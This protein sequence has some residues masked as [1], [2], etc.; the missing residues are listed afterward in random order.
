MLQLEIFISGAAVIFA[1]S[2]FFI[3]ITRKNTNLLH[4]LFA[5]VALFSAALFSLLLLQLL[6]F[7][8]IPLT[9]IGRVYIGII[10]LLGQM[11]FHSS[12][13]YPDARIKSRV[14]Q[15]ILAAIPGLG[16]VAATVGTNLV[17]SEVTFQEHLT[18]G[19]GKFYLVYV[20]LFTA[21]LFGGLIIT[22]VKLQKLQESVFRQEIIYFVAGTS[23]FLFAILLL[24]FYIPYFTGFYQLQNI[25]VAISGILILL[26]VNYSILY[27]KVLDFKMFYIKLLSWIVFFALLFTP[28]M[29]M[30]KYNTL[31]IMSRQIP[32]IGIAFLIF[33][34]LV[35]FYNF[36]KPRMESV[37]RSEYRDLAGNFTDFFQSI[38]EQAGSD[39]DVSFWDNLHTR[40]ISGFYDKFSIESASFYLFSPKRDTFVYNYSF[41]TDSVPATIES[42]DTLITCL[43]LYPNVI[44]KATLYSDKIFHKHI[45]S[46]INFFDENNIEIAMPFLNQE[47]QVIGILLLGNF[48]NKKYS[49]TFLSTLE[50]YRVRFQH[51]LSNQIR[52][53][54]VKATQ[55]VEHDKIVVKSIKNKVIPKKLKQIEGIRISSF[56]INN[57]THGGDYFDSSQLSKDKLCLFIS[58]SSYSGV[59]SAILSL[60]LYAI[61]QSL[62]QSFDTPNYILNTMNWVLATSNYST[63]HAPALCII[64][65]TSREITYSNAAYN[66]LLLF[67]PD[68]HKFETFESREIPIGVDRNHS[69]ENKTIKLLPGNIGVIY[70]DGFISAINK[71]G[72]S[73]S[74]D[75]L[76]EIIMENK[77][78]T[79]AVLTRKIYNDFNSFIKEK[80]QIN[81]ISLI[82]FKV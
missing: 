37:F 42:N 72:E 46:I 5:L 45:D 55:V 28:V 26:S 82:I 6:N 48:P 43:N 16:V 21:Y 41:G 2:I 10:I 32:D 14:T 76:K 70:S 77:F 56:Y 60:Q 1:L 68:N 49:K 34:Y 17:I 8:T 53:E 13:L 66:P 61:I 15:V 47:K 54:E 20:A 73:Y 62:T 74:I 38:S 58:D 69:Y 44:D 75:K 31:V 29:F 71:E 39:S 52:L 50:L 9:I 24:S 79:P 25:T 23:L 30:L 27:L 35:M 78:K 64:Y 40:S 51:L 19:Q 81:D 33:L 7:T 59:E 12:Q 65:S 63:K 57:S 80:K 67:T 22:I 4:K 11:F 18:Y 3:N 36:V